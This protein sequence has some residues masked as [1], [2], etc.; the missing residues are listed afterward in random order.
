MRL[1]MTSWTIRRRPFV[2]CSCEA[3]AVCR[4][5]C[6]GTPKAPATCGDSP[7]TVSRSTE[8]GAELRHGRIPLLLA[9]GFVSQQSNALHGFDV[10]WAAELVAWSERWWCDRLP[11]DSWSARRFAHAMAPL[12]D[13]R[14]AFQMPSRYLFRKVFRKSTRSL[15]RR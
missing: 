9:I 2:G 5:A 14:I 3:T 11:A 4:H 7:R 1:R 12:S 15:T 6:V 8:D 13:P 10:A